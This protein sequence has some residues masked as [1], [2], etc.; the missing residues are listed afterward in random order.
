MEEELKL[1]S[2]KYNLERNRNLSRY[3]EQIK[4]IQ[5]TTQKSDSIALVNSKIDKLTVK[6][7]LNSFKNLTLENFEHENPSFFVGDL[8][9]VMLELN[10]HDLLTPKQISSLIAIGVLDSYCEDNNI[11]I[12]SIQHFSRSTLSR[13][14]MEYYFNSEYGENGGFFYKIPSKISIDLKYSDK[15]FHIFKLVSEYLSD[16]GVNINQ[17]ELNNI[18]LFFN[19]YNNFFSKD[20]AIFETVDAENNPVTII[21]DRGQ[22][23]SV[24]YTIKLQNK[25]NLSKRF[26]SIE[27]LNQISN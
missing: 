8:G 27:L 18:Y 12:A 6:H 24:A 9:I 23:L 13:F 22:K 10:R 26:F 20:R 15:R 5:S 4:L 16:L 14:R 3:Q 11:P 2:Q 19:D 17:E 25:N 7:E 1:F 21:I